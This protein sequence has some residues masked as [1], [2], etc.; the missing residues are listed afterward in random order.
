MRA[1]VIGR[2]GPGTSLH[3]L[4]EK[5]VG[6]HIHPIRLGLL[7]KGTIVLSVGHLFLIPG[8]NKK[9]GNIGE[10]IIPSPLN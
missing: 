1:R 6:N 5:G 2:V 7:V 9:Q 4:T 10:I 8:R 3:I